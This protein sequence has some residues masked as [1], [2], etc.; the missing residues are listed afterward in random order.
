MKGLIY[1]KSPVGYLLLKSEDEYLTEL[2]FADEKSEKEI[3]TDVLISAIEELK[4]YFSK[5]R[6]EFDIPLKMK[7]T[8]FQKKCWRELQNIPYGETRSYKDIAESIG[9]PKAYRA[10]G[11]ANNK[12]P[13]SI[14]IPCHRVIGI[15]GKLVGF[16]GGL[17]KKSYLLKLEK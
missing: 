4:E 16:G 2:S 9:S 15:N 6:K 5:K 3:R 1:Y 7:G 11:L 17:D 8:D 12:N 14:I 10:V 13:I